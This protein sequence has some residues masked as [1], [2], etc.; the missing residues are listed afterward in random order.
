MATE[1]K[2]GSLVMTGL[3]NTTPKAGAPNGL[4][5]GMLRR[6][7]D[8]VEVT[9]AVS[10]GSI[11]YFASIPSDAYI[12]AILSKVEWDDM[13]TGGATLDIGDDTYT[14]GLATDIAIDTGAGNSVICEATGPA[15]IANRGKRLWEQLGHSADPGG[16]IDLRATLA[17]ADASAGG[18]LTFSVYWSRD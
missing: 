14:D 8:T 16:M 2:Y 11:Y 18:T 12:D 6:S 17:T 5:S 3:R 15:D 10:I 9:A 4:A 13:G 1:T 7:V